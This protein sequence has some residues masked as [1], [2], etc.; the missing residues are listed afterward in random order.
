MQRIELPKRIFIT[1]TDTD[2]GKTVISSLIVKGMNATYWKIIQ[3]GDDSDTGF[4]KEVTRF[5]KEKFMKEAYKLKDPL[6]PYAAAANE[7]QQ[8]EIDHIKSLYNNIPDGRLVVEGA[9]GVM[10]PVLED[11]YMSDLIKDL[12]L[13]TIVVARSGLGTLNH[14]LLTLEHL[15]NKKIDVTCVVMSGPE[16]RSNMDIIEKFSG[17]R[18]I[19]IDIFNFNDTESVEKE[20]QKNFI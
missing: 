5:P 19:G 17:I 10:V 6:S 16:N 2:V 3:T 13:D 9:G 7:G 4:I 8:I 15:K 12:G 1:G 18:T 20:F 14:T 11:Y